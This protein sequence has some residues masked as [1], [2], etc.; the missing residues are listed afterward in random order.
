VHTPVY[1]S[2]VYG[3]YRLREEVNTFLQAS[4]T[5]ATDNF[6]CSNNKVY[7]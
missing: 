1:K 2:R 7:I 6:N 3:G 5:R 4:H